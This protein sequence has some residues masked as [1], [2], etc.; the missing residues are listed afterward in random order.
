[1]GEKMAFDNPVFLFRFLPIFFVLYHIA[2]KSFRNVLLFAGSL[3]VVGWNAPV[4]ALAA[5]V[6]TLGMT[7]LG[8]MAEKLSGKT[9]GIFLTACTVLLCM[10]PL[11]ALRN[12]CSSDNPG[13]FFLPFGL[14][15]FTLQGVSYIVDVYR[16]FAKASSNPFDVGAYIFGFTGMAAGP[17]VCYRDWAEEGRNRVA[18]A[19]DVKEGIKL[20]MKGLAKKVVLGDTIYRLYQEIINL[21]PAYISAF[22]AW[23]G[24]AAFALSVYYFLSGYS[25]MAIGLRRMMGFHTE[26]N[27]LHPFISASVTEYFSRWNV[28]MKRWMTNYVYRPLG[29]DERNFI[30][31][32]LNIIIVSVLTGLW[33]GTGVNFALAG[34]WIGI[35]LCLEKVFLKSFLKGLARPAGIVYTILVMLPMGLFFHYDMPWELL[36]YLSSCV[37]LGNGLFDR[38][39][40]FLLAEYFVPLAVG[41]F[42][43]LP[44]VSVVLK[45]LE[46]SGTGL[47]IAIY[48]F[49]E[50]VIP[51]VLF[52]LAMIYLIGTVD[53]V[54]IVIWQ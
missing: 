11:I 29:G 37:G 22:T 3:F 17:V 34:V 41:A 18:T 14:S 32:M 24:L 1:M 9:A 8:V 44:L 26:E 31:T 21:N 43:A 35:F 48:H 30:V 12:I 36:P 47:G 46:N 52:L 39:G 54:S 6:F 16:G 4:V 27:F 10:F 19:Y 15:F 49:T 7:F 28:S 2:P 40:F 13:A 38:Q 20:F 33:Y 45:K 5:A 42:F 25:D 53:P 23:L 50:K 51:T